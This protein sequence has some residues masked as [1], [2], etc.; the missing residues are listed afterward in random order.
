MAEKYGTHE[1]AALLLLLIEGRQIP[2]SEMKNDHGIELTPAGRTKLNNAGLL[3][4]HKE[5]RRLV[6]EITPAGE[7]WCE[8]T[9]ATI[10]A[11]TRVSA[12]ARV[13]FEWLRSIAGYLREQGIPLRHVL[14]KGDGLESLIRAAYGELSDE[15]QD[16]V[17]LAKLRPKLNGAS[18]DEVD[19]TLLAMTRTGLVHLAQ[20]ANRKALTEDDHAAAIRIGSEDKHLVAI[21]E[22]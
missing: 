11:P 17:R 3:V 18:K 1:R 12:L 13:G 16:W 14:H 10:E 9:L 19:E 7:T 15:P 20:S 8:E 22:S 2:N 21:E 4:T 6:H 5:G